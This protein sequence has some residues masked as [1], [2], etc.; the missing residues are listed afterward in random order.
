MSE[1]RSYRRS[2]PDDCGGGREKSDSRDRNGNVTLPNGITI[3]SFHGGG[4]WVR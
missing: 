2:G 4:W 3:D 1:G